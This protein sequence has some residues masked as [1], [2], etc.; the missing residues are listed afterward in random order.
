MSVAFRSCAARTFSNFSGC[1]DSDGGDKRRVR[2]VKEALPVWRLPGA[3]SDVLSGII[4]G[5]IIIVRLLK[6]VNR[7]T[8][9]FLRSPQ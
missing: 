7:S 8:D 3:T 2:G 9:G 1:E 6:G 4:M 5:A